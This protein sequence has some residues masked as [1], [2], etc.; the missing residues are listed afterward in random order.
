MKIFTSLR[1]LLSTLKSTRHEKLHSKALASETGTPHLLN[2]VKALPVK[3]SC[4]TYVYD[5]FIRGELKYQFMESIWYDT[6]SPAQGC[7]S[8]LREIKKE[9]PY[10]VIHG[11]GKEYKIETLEEFKLWVRDIFSPTG[12]GY[13]CDFSE[14]L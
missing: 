10:V 1:H 13:V 11:F 9:L 12:C 14:Y 6:A 5:V 7:I 2:R 3:E 4:P 8:R